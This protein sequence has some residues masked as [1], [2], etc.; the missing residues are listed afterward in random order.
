MAREQPWHP[1][2][3]PELVLA[4]TN[5]HDEVEPLS[6]WCRTQCCSLSAVLSCHIALLLDTF[7]HP[8]R[9]PRGG[10]AGEGSKLHKDPTWEANQQQQQ[11][12]EKP[13]VRPVLSA[14]SSQKKHPV[15][16]LLVVSLQLP[17]PRAQSSHPPIITAPTCDTSSSPR[18]LSSRLSFS[19]SPR[20]AR[21]QPLCALR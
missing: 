3:W 8:L 20:P 21:S 5:N 1:S 12:S 7:P 10:M 17:P 9:S 15:R 19:P 18:T 14:A 11:P 13:N 4:V 16:K 2:L 6:R